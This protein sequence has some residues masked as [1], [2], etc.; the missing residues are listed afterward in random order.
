MPKR[1]TLLDG[2][3]IH[4]QVMRAGGFQSRPLV[5]PELLE[6]ALYRP[7]QAAHYEDAD[8]FLR[9]HGYGLHAVRHVVAD[10]LIAVAGDREEPERAVANLEAVLR[11]TSTLKEEQF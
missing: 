2:V 7:L 4:E 1:L 5:R 9:D 3:A 10:M 8:L 6:S 11:E